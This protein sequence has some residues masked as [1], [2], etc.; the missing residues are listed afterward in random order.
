[1]AIS[2]ALGWTFTSELNKV[3]QELTELLIEGERIHAAYKTVRDIAVFTNKRLIV[4]DSQGLT[5]R[6]KEIY[7]LPYS[8]I[9][10]WSTEN[11]GT[12]DLNSEVQLWT[13]AGEVKINLHRGVDPRK[14][15]RV[16]AEA[17]LK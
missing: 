16:L 12:I 15:D 2:N 13:R 3:P 9:N 8:A 14:L 11:A 17:C 4:M 7:S 1:M 5:G 6:K 10:M